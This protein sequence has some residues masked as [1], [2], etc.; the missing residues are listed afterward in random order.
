MKKTIDIFG[1]PFEVTGAEIDSST[2]GGSNNYL[3]NLSIYGPLLNVRL[4]VKSSDLQENKIFRE[5]CV[6]E[7]NRKEL[8]D[9]DVLVHCL[10]NVTMALLFDN[11]EK[12]AYFGAA[13]R[14]KADKSDVATGVKLATDRALGII[15][16][17]PDRLYT[18]SMKKEISNFIERNNC[19]YKVEGFE[20]ADI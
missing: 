1:I 16:L 15:P 17:I 6:T 4:T 7:K 20:Y 13:I 14:N 8:E 19:G 11:E 18:D 5:L 9:Y 10:D 2:Y 3:T 12:R